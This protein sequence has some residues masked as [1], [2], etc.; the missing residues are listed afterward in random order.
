MWNQLYFLP[1]FFFIP[2]KSFQAACDGYNDYRDMSLT[3]HVFDTLMNACG[4]LI[5]GAFLGIVWP[6]TGVVATKRYLEK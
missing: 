5:E 3:L 6:I 1:V 2:M 4:G